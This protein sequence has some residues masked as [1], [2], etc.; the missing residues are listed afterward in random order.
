LEHCSAR[1][2]KNVRLENDGGALKSRWAL[3]IA[4]WVTLPKSAKYGR[5]SRENQLISM[6]ISR[7][8]SGRWTAGQYNRRAVNEAVQKIDDCFTPRLSA[9]EFLLTAGFRGLQKTSPACQR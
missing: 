9:F 1:D 6:S 5:R 7:M 3:R 2:L 8:R 4:Y